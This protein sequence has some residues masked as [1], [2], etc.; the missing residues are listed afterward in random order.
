M[1]LRDASQAKAVPRRRSILHLDLQPF[2]VSVERALDP[3]LR[4]RPVVIGG[5]PDGSGVVAAAS[6]EAKAAGV[7]EGQPLAVARRT[8][9]Q[10]VFR[11]GDLEAYAR[12]SQE[13]T[14]L[15]LAASRRVT[16]AVCSAAASASSAARPRR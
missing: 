13:V 2:F 14:S 7:R 15:L 3:A 16:T 1:L 9:P 12:V 6:R 11:P 10:A 8:C 4:D 5:R